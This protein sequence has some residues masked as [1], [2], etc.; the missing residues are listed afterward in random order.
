LDYV[1]LKNILI[2]LDSGFIFKLKTNIKIKY[3]LF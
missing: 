2:D 3:L 1:T